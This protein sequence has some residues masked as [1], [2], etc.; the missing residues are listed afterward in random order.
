MY[1]AITAFL[2]LIIFSVGMRAQSAKNMSLNLPS[3]TM[4]GRFFSKVIAVFPYYFNDTMIDSKLMNSFK[5]L[6]PIKYGSYYVLSEKDSLRYAVTVSYNTRTKT[7]TVT[8]YQADGAVISIIHYDL[9]Y[10]KHGKYAEFFPGIGYYVYGQYKHGKEDGK[11]KTFDKKGRITTLEIFKK[12][13]EINTQIYTIPQEDSFT[14]KHK[15][16]VAD[17]YNISPYIPPVKKK[18]K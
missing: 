18:K 8:H 3:K 1:K 7:Y 16:V 5:Y 9:D 4:P 11:W 15:A 2:L 17:P 6:P 14:K 12:G 13:T 10:E